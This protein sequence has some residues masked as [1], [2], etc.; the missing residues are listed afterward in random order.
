MKLS[1]WGATRQVTGS[2]YLIELADSSKI[3]IDC[4]LQY[5]SGDN[6]EINDDFPFN[7]NEIDCVILT[8]AHID[9]SVNLPT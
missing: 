9:N 8:H 5:E 6:I 1:F 4:G 7:P 2:M 3:L